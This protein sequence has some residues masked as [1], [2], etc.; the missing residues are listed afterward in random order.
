MCLGHQL[1]ISLCEWLWHRTRVTHVKHVEFVTPI[2]MSLRVRGDI[3]LEHSSHVRTSPAFFSFAHSY[4]QH[5]K[6]RVLCLSKLHV[7]SQ[8]E[9]T[10]QRHSAT[11][12]AFAVFSAICQRGVAPGGPGVWA[13][14]RCVGGV[15]CDIHTFIVRTIPLN[16]NALSC[17]RV[18][19][20]ARQQRNGTD[21]WYCAH[22]LAVSSVSRNACSYCVLLYGIQ[23]W[24]RCAIPAK[25][26]ITL[27]VWMV[28]KNM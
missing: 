19:G 3:T 1:V 15:T 18:R 5:I 14:A 12:T 24:T 21:N 6:H 16:A 20:L 27:T 10:A 7:T 13:R 9:A 22:V 23:Q 26:V 17:D 8:S 25:N 28:L 2:K 11:C 4:E